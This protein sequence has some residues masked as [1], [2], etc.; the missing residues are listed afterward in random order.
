MNSEKSAFLL[1]DYQNDFVDPA[2]ALYVR[3]AETINNSIQQIIEILNENKVQ[4]IASKD[5]HPKKHR[6]F[7]SSTGAQPFSI[8]EWSMVWPDHCVQNTRWSNL[9]WN[10]KDENFEQIILKAY[11][12]N[13]D[14]Y[15]AFKWTFLNEYLK[16][17][18]VKNL[19]IW[20]VATDYCVDQSVIDANQ[21]WLKVFV[22]Q[23]AIKAVFPENENKILDNWKKLWIQLITINKLRKIFA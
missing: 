22:I 17:K 5:W 9:Y 14:A 23:E 21:L 8:V 15:S 13:E 3:W 12:Q 2:W 1:V 11:N 16:S 7:A 4:L 19:F 6:S 10:L 18:W 20:W